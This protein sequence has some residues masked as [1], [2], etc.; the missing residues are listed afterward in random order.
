MGIIKQI[1]LVFFIFIFG[2][3]SA[4]KS[5]DSL[6]VKGNMYI[7]HIIQPNE[8]YMSISKKYNVSI[9][10]LRLH[11]QN[12]QLYFK[13]RFLIPIKSTL[14]DRLI[15]KDKNVK[16]KGL[17][18]YNI[19]QSESNFDKKD[20]L[21]IAVLLPFYITENDSLLS[22]LS[23]SDQV[24]EDI[25]KKSFMALQFLEGL[26]I[27]SDSISK[28]GKQ[29]NLYVFDTKNDTNAIKEIIAT[30][31]LESIDFIIGPVFTK[32]LSIIT[33][34]Y[35][36]DKNIQII[37]PLSRNSSVLKHGNNI[38]QI[39]PP[40]KNQINKIYQYISKKY[41]K[42]KILILAQKEEL[43]YADNYKTLFKKQKRK[44]KVCIFDGL[45]TITKDTISQFLSKHDYLVLIP[46][47]DRSF[48]SKI[49]SS[50]GTIDTN[51][52]V[53]G[54]DKWHSFENMDIET[55]MRLNVHFPNPYFFSYDDNKR[56]ISLFKQKYFV[57]P[58]KYAQIA[59]KQAMYFFGGTGDYRFKK[60]YTKGGFANYKFPIVMYKDYSIKK[61]TQ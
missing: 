21:D 61:V 22:Y 60:Y 33:K 34:L 46:S 25:Y 20:T 55:L 32:N 2:N 54:L 42:E 37:S 7:T 58:D 44:S 48:V 26:I 15:F 51:M 36:S 4:Q 28:S 31:I 14:A 12:S 56:F 27:A 39:I 57:L 16:N 30:G 13:Q 6:I 52:I 11:N 50:L 35:G 41:K 5:G 29:I 49:I 47:N 10:E 43:K 59:F 19:I 17:V 40:V 18:N 24:K 45:N 9:N 53:F 38:F 23:K 1:I 8:T 3:L